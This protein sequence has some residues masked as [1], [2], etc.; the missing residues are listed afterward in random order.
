MGVTSKFSRIESQ[1]VRV[2]VFSEED[3]AHSN[4][5]LGERV[6]S[7]STSIYKMQSSEEKGTARHVGEEEDTTQP[8]SRRLKWEMGAQCIW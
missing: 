8:L 5:E 1:N 7:A 2:S 4:R 3:S 6:V